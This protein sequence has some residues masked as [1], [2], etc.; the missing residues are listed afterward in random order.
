MDKDLIH[1]Q[2]LDRIYFNCQGLLTKSDEVY[3]SVSVK[4]LLIMYLSKTH[5]E[6]AISRVEYNMSGHNMK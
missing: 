2:S 3:Y 5:V 6:S 1:K 4:K